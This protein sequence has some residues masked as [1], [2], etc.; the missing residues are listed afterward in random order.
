MGRKIISECSAAVSI[1]LFEVRTFRT[2]N[3][4]NFV[5]TE[6]D[7]PQPGGAGCGTLLL[8]I[9]RT[10]ISSLGKDCIPRWR[11]TILD[12]SKPRRYFG[13]GKELCSVKT[14]VSIEYCVV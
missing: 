9:E 3:P 1:S 2:E 13:I 8:T 14:E 6:V 5:A 7:M 11:A 12:P 10:R 4:E